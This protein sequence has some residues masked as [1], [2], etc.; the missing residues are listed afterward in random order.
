MMHSFEYI[1]IF[2][3]PAGCL[4]ERINE[5]IS[6]LATPNKTLNVLNKYFKLPFPGWISNGRPLSILQHWSI[7]NYPCK[8]TKDDMERTQTEI[9]TGAL[10]IYRYIDSFCIIIKLFADG[11]YTY[12]VAWRGFVIKNVSCFQTTAI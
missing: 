10:S 2:P 7:D 8:Y 9:N 1:Y 6:C 11:S 12:S 4:T 3:L 5:T